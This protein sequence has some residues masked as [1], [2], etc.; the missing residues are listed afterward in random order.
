MGR[1]LCKK[2][3]MGKHY[4][5][6][7]CAVCKKEYNWVEDE[8]ADVLVEKIFID[9]LQKFIDINVTAKCP[10]CNYRYTYLYRIKQNQYR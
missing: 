2:N 8:N 3:K 10:Y 5:N 4:D 6:V 9:G 1:L 7:N